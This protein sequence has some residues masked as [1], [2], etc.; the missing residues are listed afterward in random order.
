MYRDRRKRRREVKR[1]WEQ[2][3]RGAMLPSCQE[4]VSVTVQGNARLDVDLSFKRVGLDNFLF[5]TGRK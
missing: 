4:D 2:H 1:R 5:F 3:R